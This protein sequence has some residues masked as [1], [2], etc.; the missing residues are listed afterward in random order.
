[1]RALKA[2]LFFVV[3][4]GYR[5]LA[6]ALAAIF[7][8]AFFVM[9][10]WGAAPIIGP[11]DVVSLLNAAWRILNGQIPHV[12]YHNPIGLLTYLP[13]VFGMKFAG[14][15]TSA[16]VYGSVLLAA[17]LLPWAWALASSRL[18]P[19]V[20]FLF[21]LFLGFL[22]IAPRPLGFTLWETTYAMIY[23]REGYVLL[24]MLFITLFVSARVSAKNESRFNGLSSGLLLGLILYCKITFFAV[25]AASMVFGIILQRRSKLWF[26][27]ALAGF[28]GIVAAFYVFFHFSPAA[29]ISD[30]VT[31]G[32]SQLP[33]LRVHLLQQALM[34]N[35]LWI[36]LTL[37]FL[38]LWTYADRSSDVEAL[39]PAR[40]WLTASWIVASALFID[41]GNA[42]QR[43]GLDDPLFF[44]AAVIFVELFRRRNQDPMRLSQSSARSVYAAT[45]LVLMPI[46]CGTI[47]AGD[48]ASFAYSAK[49]NLFS[50]PTFEASRQ[51]RARPLRDLR[52]P[53]TPRHITSYW[54]ASEFPFRINEGLDLVR[55]HLSQSDRITTI[56]FTDP[57]SFAFGLRPAR[58]GNQW[59]DLNMNFNRRTHPSP[60]EF[61]G[62]ASLVMLPRHVPG[63]Q[64]G[65]FDT[66]D[67]MLEL[68]GQ[69][70]HTN[71][72]PIDSSEGWILYRRR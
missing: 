22:L 34:N 44:A 23:N 61:L 57:F 14:P 2:C 37:V 52:V 47:L 32:R 40:I 6:Y 26:I 5:S 46:F 67:V 11:W 24:S 53:T 3:Q 71:F 13:I 12:D 19:W 36:Y 30:I 27:G 9:I 56:G 7:A 15:S 72:E 50:R 64:G 1:M 49:W 63:M 10:R 58:D 25:A 48:L 62:D 69:F 35:L 17:L 43:G 59:W 39:S 33:A 18:Q 45:V 42:A 21:V 51:I 4:P 16:I 54:P 68:Y 55:K 60:G 20:S 70:L 31:A 41:S 28:A 65:G 38:G 8:A 29:Y 66:R